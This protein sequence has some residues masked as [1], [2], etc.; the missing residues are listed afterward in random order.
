[1]T[2]DAVLLARKEGG[3]VLQECRSE[4]A[5]SSRKG[6]T[7][8][9]AVCGGPTSSGGR[10]VGE[11][12]TPNT[13]TRREAESRQQVELLVYAAWGDERRAG[14]KGEDKERTAAGAAH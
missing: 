11:R 14:G 8:T 6:S 4:H 9:S 5:W 12:E 10:R 7:A 13:L 1:M 2:K 3:V